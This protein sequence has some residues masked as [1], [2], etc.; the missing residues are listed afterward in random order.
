M[1]NINSEIRNLAGKVAI[2]TGAARNMGRAFS[3]AMAARGAD[4]VVHYNSE[5]SQPAAEET[6]R[7]IEAKGARAL[8]VKGDLTSTESVEKLFNDT[9][10]SFSKVD[11]VINNAGLVIKKPMA[12]YTEED[13]DR[14]FAINAKA[15]F[16]VMKQAA[17]HIQEN[18]RVINM[19]TSLLGAFT[20][21]YGIYAG[22]K[23]P[24]EDFTR[25]L[26]KEIGNRGVTVNTVAPGP[27]DTP[28]FHS[29]ENEQSVA[30]LSA[31]S[32]ANRLGRIEDIVP[33]IEF[34]V[35]EDARWT[36]GQTLFVNGGFVTR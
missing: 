16:L 14:S 27:I 31:A 10:Q 5:S 11:I 32:V 15:P 25:A 12:E 17:K 1:N 21:M 35:S 34:L 4:I 20:G 26:A 23:A 33:T 6:A 19:G 2:V 24:L 30:Y 22:S 3:V 29:E 7:L 36:T 9:I 28:F 13:F 8:L 18:G